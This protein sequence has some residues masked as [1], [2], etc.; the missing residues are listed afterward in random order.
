MQ[1]HDFHAYIY[2]EGC[3]YR[4]LHHIVQKHDANHP[5]LFDKLG[6]RPKNHKFQKN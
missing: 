1:N 3:K 6:Y 2:P 4:R 5:E